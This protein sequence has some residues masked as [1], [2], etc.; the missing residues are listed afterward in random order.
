MICFVDI[1]HERWLASP[2]TRLSHLAFCMD[3]KLK[4]EEISGSPCIVQRYDDLTRQSLQ[5]LGITALVISGNAVGFEEYATGAF[6][7]L[8]HIVREAALPIIGFCGGHQLIAAAHGVLV[9]PMRRLRP[10]ELDVTTLSAP[11]YLK[12]WGFMPVH[13]VQQDPVFEG[14]GPSPEFL[15]VHY[16]EAK[17]LPPGFQ[18]LA[19]TGDCRIQ[20]IKRVDRPVYGTQFH[21]EAYTEGPNDRRNPL[22]SLVYPEG[23]AQGQ[24]AGRILLANF[25]RIVGVSR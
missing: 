20:M 17:K 14:M 15:E 21:P 3:V 2:D 19:S 23:R 16:C 11:G 10:D 22:V 1:E 7:E 25:F 6:S 13:V 5:E 18:L 9:E 24:P 12:E 8:H 4:L